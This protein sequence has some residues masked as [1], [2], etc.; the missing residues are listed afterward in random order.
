MLNWLSRM[1]DRICAVLGALLFMQFPL[2][3]QQYTMRLSGHVE[4]LH[5]QVQ[6]MHEIAKEVG[7]TLPQYIE[8]FTLNKD[9]DIA[10]QGDLMEAMIR[11]MNELSDAVNSLAD[12]N[13]FTRPFL[14]LYHSNWDIV[15]STLS[16]YRIGVTLTI[17]SIIYGIVGVIVGYYTY[18]FVAGFCRRVYN[19]LM[20]AKK[21]ESK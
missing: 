20:R 14:F 17:E 10:K 3:L 8:K 13:V 15:K 11:R 4:E 16:S 12:A 6:R 21:K 1:L 2:F 9:I 19:G 5:Y 7:K 18:Q